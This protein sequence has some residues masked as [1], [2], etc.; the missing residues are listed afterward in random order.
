MAVIVRTKRFF[1]PEIQ[2]VNIAVIKVKRA[3]MRLE[4]GTLLICLS[5]GVDD[6]KIPAN[7]DTRRRAQWHQI[8]FGDGRTEIVGC[9]RFL[10]DRHIDSS[11]PLRQCNGGSAR[12][13]G[14]DAKGDCKQ[15]L[16]FRFVIAVTQ[17][18]SLIDTVRYKRGRR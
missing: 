16:P 4:G 6:R 2:S 11:F 18:P 3:L 13:A 10:V 17:K 9:K 1:R 12:H 8:R 14:I 5:D 7:Y 15:Q